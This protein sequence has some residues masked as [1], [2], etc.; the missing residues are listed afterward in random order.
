MVKRLASL[1]VVCAALQAQ[2][3]AC[4][5]GDTAK[6]SAELEPGET[7]PG[8]AAT[9]TRLF[10]SN[11]F[12]QH[13][14]TLSRDEEREFFTGNSFFSQSWVE[15][16][17]S[18]TARDGVGP[19]FNARACSG[20]HFKD[21]RGAPPDDDPTQVGLL[22]RISIDGHGEHGGPV[23]DPNYGDQLQDRGIPDVPAE[24]QYTI[25]HELID[26][27]YEDGEA[28]ELRAPSYIIHD[29]AFGDL[30]ADIRVSPRL[31]PQVIGMGLLEAIPESRLE[32][33]A[34]PDDDDGDGISGRINR[35]WD[36]EAEAMRPG[37]LGWK[38]EQPSVLQQ[39]AG[40]FLGD[41]GATSRVF[42]EQNCPMPQLECADAPNGGEPEV[43]DS[44]LDKVV[45]YTKT[46]AVPARR[47]PDDPGVLH[48]K[49]LFSEAG[50]DGCHVAKHRTGE[51]EIAVLSEQTIF[52]FTDLLLHDMGDALGDDRPVFDAEGNEWR[53]PPLWG[54][55]LIHEVNGH[56]RLMHDG[57]ARGVAEAILWHGGEAE[58]A[59]ESF[60]TMAVEDR[61]A[62]VRFVKSL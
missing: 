2:A 41:I 10:G 61:D 45:L 11:S 54:I 20:C 35:V 1:F 51:A 36:R 52:P 48:G 44:L 13:A 57:R 33:L 55:G 9:N 16:P 24:G 6:P 25:E 14:P 42:P 50:C 46:L 26:G 18:T 60:R 12:N 31:A 8:G 38:A 34:D 32:Q 40:A 43:Q 4:G 7:L 15:A 17:A 62:L 23:G 39:S 29:L 21:G 27:E 28:Y 58:A 47:S 3:Q 53:T 56:E 19:T 59:K 37:R 30:D 5:D 49:A 22:L